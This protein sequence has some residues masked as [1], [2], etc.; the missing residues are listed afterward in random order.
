MKNHFVFK[1]TILCTLISTMGAS[2]MASP[3]DFSQIPPGLVAIPPTPNVILTVDDSGSMGDSVGGGDTKSKMFRLKE[4]LGIV[5]NDKL[6]L[7]DGKIRLAWQAMWNNGKATDA[8]SLTAGNI[9]SMKVLDET[10]RT[11]FLSFKDSLQANNGTPSHK[12]MKQAYDYMKTGKGKNSPWAFR[13]GTTEEPYLGCR[14][15][16][17]I[18]M[19]DGAWNGQDSSVR[20]GNIDNTDLIFPDGT[21]YDTKSSQTNVYRGAIDNLLADWALKMWAEDLQPEISNQIKPSTTDGVP[22]TENYGSVALQ[23]YWNPKHNPATWQHLVHYTIGYGEDAYTWP[24]APAWSKTD[25]DNYGSGGDFSKLVAGSVKW[26]PNTFGNLNDNNPAELWHMAINSR[27]KFYPTGPGRK[28]DLKEAFRKILENINQENSAD[29]ASMAA[30]STTNIR[31]DVNKFVAGFDP[32]KWS[33]YVYASRINTLGIESAEPNW[34]TN[35]SQPAPKDRMTTAQKLDARAASDRVI[36]TTNDSTNKGVSF[37]WATDT[38]KLS[39]NQKNL[40]N[41]DGKGEDRLRFLR[42]DRSKEGSTSTLPFRVRDSSQGDIINSNVWY[43]ASPAS[44]YP[45]AGY[46]SFTS[47]HKNRLPMIYVGG[48]DGMLH[49]FSAQDGEEKLA[50]IP[51]AV[52]P[53]LSKLSDPSYSHRY[54]VD[55]SPFTGDAYINPS[56]TD[57][58]T[59]QWSTL[60]VGT[61]G[62]GGKGYFILDV[63][64]PGSKDGTTT[65]TTF[66]T[67][68]AATLVVMDKTIHPATP[69]TAGSD[70]EDIG[71]I[72]APPVVDDTNPF[73]ASQIALLNNDRWAVVLGNGYNSKK[74][75]P[76]LLIQ[77]LDGTK[78]LK[79]I[80]ATGSQAVSTPIDTVK[81]ENVLSN[82]LS[83]P[84]LVDINSD[85]KI[86][87]IY[88]GDLKGNL[89][90][91][92]LTS[93]DD[94]NWGVASFEGTPKPLFVA[95]YTDGKRQP[96]SAPPIVKANDR[97]AGGMMVAFG[98]GVN[99]TDNDRSSTAV[100]TVYSILDN[101]KYINKDISDGGGIAINTDTAKGGVAPE[102]V[103][104]RTKLVK[105]D[106]VD[107]TGIAG[108]GVSTGRRFWKMTS[109][110]VKYNDKDSTKNKKGWYFDF[111]VSSE[112]VLDAMSFFD[113]SNNLMVTS[114]TPAYGGNGTGQ[115]SCEPAGTAEKKYLT[116]MNI[117]D[118]KPPTVQVMDTNGDGLYSKASD[119]DQGASR[120]S[121]S[122][123]ASSNTVG[124]DTITHTGADGKQDKFARMPE[125]S[126]RPSWRQLQ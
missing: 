36:L 112:R 118:G 103:D 50:Y 73:K 56:I 3:L 92:D 23:R 6:L 102:S 85:G 84:K 60:L 110:D 11:N 2:S 39:A 117:M 125:Q 104:G 42:G 5:F 34:G 16:Y 114:I 63:T 20:P 90:K 45:H 75:R 86:D 69:L 58:T 24:D 43:V 61:L 119:K 126:M 88:A 17:H 109:N 78:A 99:V 93:K 108:S 87:I 81:D 29:V 33:G 57:T 46:K 79:K 28:Y 98:T 14:R 19:T 77:Y 83:A 25:D 101:T 7:P 59:K 91:F 89:W 72:F 67:S 44:N 116:L 52:Y 64:Q 70:E 106:M 49:G 53:D 123:G 105:Q 21:K 32:K 12:M 62:A 51:K 55:G 94:N 80:V 82:G 76:V 115:E 65:P 1:K 95:M 100:Q 22:T 26:V 38:T 48:N 31:T 47:I 120:M 35:T 107:T 54:Y 122:S 124:K 30:N 13:P 96:I 121:I 27:G 68:N 111:Q 8:G 15:S 9:N 97:G 74:E 66:T 40:L 41:T 18:F 10:H 113:A 4:A 37:E 71:H